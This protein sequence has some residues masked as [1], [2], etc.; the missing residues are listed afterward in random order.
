[1]N[2]GKPDFITDRS[3]AV[4][5]RLRKIDERL[6]EVEKIHTRYQ[7]P[8]GRPGKDAPPP[9][10][11]IGTVTSGEPADAKIRT[12]DGTFVLDLCLPRGSDGRDGYSNV[13]GP[14]GRDGADA[15]TTIAV[16]QVVSGREAMASLRHEGDVV[17]LDL[18]L[19]RGS[20]GERGSPGN[21]PTEGEL[22]TLIRSVI[23]ENPERFR[24]ASGVPGR[25]GRDGVGLRG[26]I[27]KP[28]DISAAVAQAEQEARN[29]VKEALA[30]I[31]VRLER[32]EAK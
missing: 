23:D 6:A 27:G 14:A 9:K 12:V 10:I 15:L 31:Q 21:S 5:E 18:V 30:E 26:P 25:D 17:I 16:G 13:P 11:V 7:G 1:M 2:I 20:Q 3:K 19:P 22:Q 29:I 28:G 24:G 8:P 32:L 4:E